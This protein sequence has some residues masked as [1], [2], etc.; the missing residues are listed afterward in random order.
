MEKKE[1]EFIAYSVLS[2]SECG[3]GAY[4]LYV[5]SIRT[6]GRYMIMFK[7]DNKEELNR[8]A[9]QINEVRHLVNENRKDTENIE[10]YVM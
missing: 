1:S 3:K 2:E 8:V 7:S 5:Q 9:E 6:E 10:A 4:T